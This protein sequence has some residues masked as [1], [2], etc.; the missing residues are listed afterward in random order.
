MKASDEHRGAAI[1]IAG[2]HHVL[3]VGTRQGCPEARALDTAKI[4]DQRSVRAPHH[5]AGRRAV[6]GGATARDQGEIEHAGNGVLMLIEAAAFDIVIL[7]ALSKGWVEGRIAH[8][9]ASHEREIAM[10]AQLIATHWTC[11]CANEQGAACGCTTE[12]RARYDARVA[13]TLGAVIQMAFECTDNAGHDNEW[14]RSA[15]AKSIK[16]ARNVQR[17]RW[18]TSNA[19]AT[20][21]G[22]EDDLAR[23]GTDAQRLLESSTRS[24]KVAQGRRMHTVR[25]ARTIADLDGRE[26]MSACDI[27]EAAYYQ[28]TM[29][30]IEQSA[31]LAA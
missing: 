3:I 22:M 31:K 5:S 12:A 30:T 9:N 14:N 23:A 27:A 15:N 2:E 1:A 24:Q 17:L 16:R 19:K 26:I 13:H 4:D 28:R 20:S 10:A 7:H 11:P 25:V 6:L 8:R 29:T 21:Q 18:G